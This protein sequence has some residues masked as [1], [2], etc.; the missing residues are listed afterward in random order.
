M[1]KDSLFMLVLLI[2]LFIVNFIY[3]KIVEIG[4]DEIVAVTIACWVILVL[5]LKI[6]Y[7]RNW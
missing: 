5:W 3:G 4:L 1:K 2:G 7:K 6:S